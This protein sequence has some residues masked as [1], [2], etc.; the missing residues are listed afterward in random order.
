MFL[1]TEVF[2]TC[3]AVTQKTTFAKKWKK[4]KQTY[5]QKTTTATMAWTWYTK[6]VRSKDK[7]AHSNNGSQRP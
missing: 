4:A 2:K 1:H 7:N 5:K 6:Y 3:Y